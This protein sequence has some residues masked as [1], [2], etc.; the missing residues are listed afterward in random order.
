MVCLNEFVLF[1]DFAIQTSSNIVCSVH[2]HVHVAQRIFFRQPGLH[3]GKKIMGYFRCLKSSLKTFF[4]SQSAIS[5]FAIA[6]RPLLLG[7]TKETIEVG[8]EI[9]G[10]SCSIVDLLSQGSRR[11]QQSG[12]LNNL[13][14]IPQR[15]GCTV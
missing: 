9:S 11:V 3:G 1:T 2:A 6:V 4:K 5:I 7:H 13:G 12:I 14:V 10:R 15:P 8:L